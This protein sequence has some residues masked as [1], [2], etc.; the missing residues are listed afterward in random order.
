MKLEACDAK[1]TTTSAISSGWPNR[2]NG[3]IFSLYGSFVVIGVT[4]G[5]GAIP[6]T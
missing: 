3:T 1:K 5:P 2:P 6:L 4:I